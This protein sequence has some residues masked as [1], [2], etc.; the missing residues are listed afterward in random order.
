MPSANPELILPAR[1]IRIENTRKIGAAIA[2][3]EQGALQA[4]R[5]HVRALAE[6]P[7]YGPTLARVAARAIQHGYGS[8]G[9]V[10]LVRE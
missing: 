9:T 2:T 10:G 5:I 1:P 7:E 8:R 3:A 4:H 6:V